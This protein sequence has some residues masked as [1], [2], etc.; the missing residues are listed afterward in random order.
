MRFFDGTSFGGK[1]H[2]RKDGILRKRPIKSRREVTNQARQ[3]I[4]VVWRLGQ[5]AVKR[6]P[7][8]RRVGDG[9]GVGHR[10]RA[11]GRAGDVIIPVVILKE[12]DPPKAA[13]F[14]QFSR[15][16]RQQQWDGSRQV[17]RVQV[18]IGPRILGQAVLAGL[19]LKIEGDVLGI[20]LKG[21]IG[22]GQRLSILVGKQQGGIGEVVN[23]DA[24]HQYQ[25]THE[26]RVGTAFPL[27]DFDRFHVF[28]R[29]GF[30]R[31]GG[32]KKNF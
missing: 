27:A 32:L 18:T 10:Q 11:V 28:F 9:L 13:P 30:L 2:R 4:G 31:G 16:S 14:F 15:N 23:V 25:P 12:G 8:G 6:Q 20:G 3:G 1:N 17:D 29:D 21:H 7:I 5:T 22:D 26:A 19:V 24:R